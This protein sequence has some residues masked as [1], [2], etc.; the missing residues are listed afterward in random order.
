MRSNIIE[1]NG[2]MSN[3]RNKIILDKT[4]S[5]YN[6]ENDELV[7]GIV[8]TPD[9]GELLDKKIIVNGSPKSKN[10]EYENSSY[11]ERSI[12]SSNPHDASNPDDFDD[13]YR[14]HISK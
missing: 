10:S 12:K 11:N 9:D 2:S 8:R 3:K 4:N 5:D 6:S 7:A 13:N 1:A 14:T